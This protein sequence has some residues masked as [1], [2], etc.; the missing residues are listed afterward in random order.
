MN[1]RELLI[2][3]QKLHSFIKKSRVERANK[4]KNLKLGL[5]VNIQNCTF[6]FHNYINTGVS[7]LN[8]SLGDHTYI[9]AN[10]SIVNTRIGK[11]CS[12]ANNV[13]IG[14]GKHPSNFIS[15]HPA[16]YT[17]NK[18]FKTFA[19]KKYF[20]ESEQTIIENDVW[21]GNNAIIIG[22]ITIGNGSIIAAGSVVT[23]DVLPYSV[24]GGVPAKTIKF[25]F[26]DK[27]I[28]K[29]N[30]F[31]WWNKGEE[32]LESNFRYFHDVATFLNFIEH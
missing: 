22:G 15:T 29:L 28:E 25:R 20:Q 30:E 26:D 9:N 32:W 4:E 6:G 21:I 3:P 8:T 19:D 11:F 31:Q 17:N 2:S 7:M 13:Q 10:S 14:L 1:Y 12:I 5:F 24:V 18:A 23:K 16:F 27:V